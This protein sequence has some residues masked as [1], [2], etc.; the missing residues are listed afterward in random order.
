M[1]A[2]TILPEGISTTP[3][4]LES[5]T[6]YLSSSLSQG[7]SSLKTSANAAVTNGTS[8]NSSLFD[9]VLVLPRLVYKAGSFA[10]FTVP[11][12]FNAIGLNI[13]GGGVSELAAATG[14]GMVPGPAGLVNSQAAQNF[15]QGAGG[16]GGGPTA[17]VLA[18]EHLA[19]QAAAASGDR[20]GFQHVRSLG[21][22][23]TYATSPWALLCIFMVSYGHYH[24]FLIIQLIINYRLQTVVLNRTFV[25]ASLRRPLSLRWQVRLVLRIIPVVLFVVQAK[26]IL[27]S[28]QCQSSPFYATKIYGTEQHPS[29]ETGVYEA[30]MHGLSSLLLFGQDDREACLAV[31]MIPKNTVSSDDQTITGSLSLLWPLF[32]TLCG[33]TFV[34]VLSAAVQSRPLQQENGMTIFEHSLAFAESEAMI[35]NQQGWGISAMPLTEMGANQTAPILAAVTKS[36]TRAQAL[37]QLNAPL[38]VLFIALVSTFQNLTTQ[39]LGVFDCQGK[40]RLISTGLWGLCFMSALIYSIL[41]NTLSEYGDS[42]IFKFPTVCIVGFIPHLLILVGILIC[43][44]IYGIALLLSVIAPP[45]DLRREH[46]TMWQRLKA[47]HENLQANIQ[48]SSLRI[49]MHDDF[50]QLLLKIGFVCLSA[51]TE[52]VYLNEGQ[53]VGVRKWTWL[54]EERIKEIEAGRHLRNRGRYTRAGSGADDVAEGVGLIDQNVG[55]G[56]AWTSGYTKERT[57]NSMTKNVHRTQAALRADPTH[58]DRGT[59]WLGMFGF[60]KGIWWLLV[61]WLLAALHKVLLAGGITW[62]PQWL[63]RMISPHKSRGPHQSSNGDIAANASHTLEFWLM[64]DDGILSLPENMDID[65]AEE[66]RKRRAAEKNADLTRADEKSLDS[67]TYGWW[68]NGGWWGNV[69][70]SGEFQPKEEFD[71]T[72]VISTSFSTSSE[73]DDPWESEVE[74][75]GRRTPTQQEPHADRASRDGT[76]DLDFTNFGPSGLADLLQPKTVEDRQL[77]L[78]RVLPHHLR[79]SGI[80]TR[81]GYRAAQEADRAKIL[82]STR[83]RPQGFVQT[84]PGRLSPTEESNLLEQMII[85]RRAFSNATSTDTAGS[86]N[87][88]WADGAAGMG[89]AGPQC[90]VCQS[91]PRT[92]LIW[93]CRCLALCE[94]CRVSLAMNNFGNCVCCRREVVAFSR[95]YVP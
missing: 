49:S 76:P 90:V 33:A 8:T 81:S 15:L 29:P 54:E 53:A 16:R 92:I 87:G 51:A 9:T 63:Q 83:F 70:N 84:D 7:F 12:H 77:D 50:Y 56:S 95:I 75:S 47:A 85:D 78:A 41:I 52:A 93:P 59:R 37:A 62:R 21:G 58:G 72:S 61:T 22:V 36:I 42:G 24:S 31:G 18:A 64:S 13:N 88:S 46:H 40:F 69:D 94:E 4:L 19:D 34:D 67:D 5:S 39:I 73:A 44:N 10:L 80:L 82:T 91:A 28:I 66:M 17:S 65:V 48:F 6:A 35:S 1:A 3:S 71:T 89:A 25:Y 60:F 30:F 45:E 79:S 57:T 86:K 2:T 68:L 43:A 38:E 20:N 55:D 23:F 14:D 11:E 74:E 32:V 26:R 27:Q